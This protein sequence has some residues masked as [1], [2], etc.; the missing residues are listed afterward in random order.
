MS[1]ELLEPVPVYPKRWH[2]RP[3]RCDCH[4]ETC[5]C[6]PYSIYNPEG[7]LDMPAFDRK[8]AK[9]YVDIKNELD[10]R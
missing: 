8:K 3:N 2:V 7:V 10:K 4:P 6:A 9:E 1:I 5:C